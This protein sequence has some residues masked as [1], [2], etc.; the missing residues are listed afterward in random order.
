MKIDTEEM[1]EEAKAKDW[2]V[3]DEKI[4]REIFMAYRDAFE[5]IIKV[6]IP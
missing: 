6:I 4:V 1:I 5:K 2:P 3:A